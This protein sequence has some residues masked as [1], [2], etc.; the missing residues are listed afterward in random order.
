[1]RG[2]ER[3]QEELET[4]RGVSCTSVSILLLVSLICCTRLVDYRERMTKDVELPHTSHS[5]R[6]NPGSLHFV[7]DGVPC[8]F[9]RHLIIRAQNGES[10][11]P[12]TGTVTTEYMKVLWPHLFFQATFLQIEI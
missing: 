3:A 1:M 9:K 12:R 7:Q 2:S 11:D 5:G 6:T 4:D 10:L 8:R